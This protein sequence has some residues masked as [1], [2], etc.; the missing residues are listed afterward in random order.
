MGKLG[1]LLQI[2][3]T[4]GVR[5]GLLRL[6]YE[7]Q[8]GSGLM[9]R[10]M[11]SVR[12][13]E[14]W[15]LK[16]IAPK[17]SPE[18]LLSVRRQ[19]GR[20]FFFSDSRSLAPELGRIL[21][22][23]GARS[24]CVEGRG[25]LEGNLPFFGR[26]SFACGFPPQWFQNPDTGQH[27]SPTRPWTQM[28]FASGVGSDDYGDL[29]FI[30]EP[31]RFLFVYPLARAYAI[32]GDER[33]P[34]AFWSAIE[35]WAGKS[36]PMSGPLWICGQESS[37]RILAWSFALY[38]LLHSP[39]TTPQRVALLLSMIAAHAWR[40]MRTV[41]YAR[42]QRSNHLFS[43]AVGLWTAGTLYPELTD[44]AAWQR[45]GALLLRE[46]VLDQITPEGASL[47]DS[48]NYQRMVL[49]LLLWTLR[50]S[51]IYKIDLDSQ[52]RARTVAAFEFIREFV[53]SESGRAPN[54][55]SNDGSYILPLTA[56]DYSDY[57]PLLRL[58]SCIL[59]RPNALPRGPWDE[60]ALWFCG[61]SAKSA[62]G[63]PAYTVTS[64]AGYHRVGTENS[65][66]LV[67]A[68]RYT[69]RP[70]QADQL[71]V[72]LWY[73]G[74]NLARDAGTYLYNGE[75][76]WNNGLAGTAVHNTVMVDRQDQMRRAGRF[77][78]L[79]WAQASGRSFSTNLSKTSADSPDCFEGEHNGYRRIGV[80][81]RRTVQSITEDAWV[82]VD[83]LLGAGEHELRLHWLLPDLPLEVSA[84]SPFC[85]A[86]S[87]EKVRFHWNVFCSS[88]GS[89]AV[90]RGGK[91]LTGGPTGGDEELL[92][93]ES[94]TYGERCPAISLL[95][96]VQAAL[97][98]RIVTATLAGEA[99]QLSQ[100]DGQLVLSR[101]NSQIYQVSLAAVQ[102][103]GADG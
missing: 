6:E 8:R 55:G 76:P 9:S 50:L 88:P 97:P 101:E 54:H 74:L 12:G 73:H 84:S 7:L 14:S 53:D 17:T 16:Q 99:V 77:L 20:P 95:Y 11:R 79:D 44:A 90:I 52:I 35:D 92:G 36:P 43:E 64:A 93:W 27:V 45:Q 60:A 47:Q 30:L 72:D 31:S 70:F 58:G 10:R 78:W 37:L 22:E 71:H 86:F 18:D 102:T 29:K 48:F 28:R 57:R 5:D 23:E 98:V 69:R 39:A 59:D 49:H 65:W 46:A 67:R 41:G 96:H 2:G 42:S 81:H 4:F 33:F 25:I 61:K 56:C 24:V 19:G 82:I 68:G 85:A 80:K 34:A 66:A 32:S 26:L 91:V 83:D 3:R 62:E 15:D 63:K 103:V 13:W 38:A 21:G 89:A 94:P 1:T 51:E 40:T 87:A 75:P 100:S